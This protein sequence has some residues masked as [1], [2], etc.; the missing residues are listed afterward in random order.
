[1]PAAPALSHTE[2]LLAVRVVEEAVTNA[3]RHGGASRVD[4]VVREEAG[5]LQ[6]VVT[7]N[8]DGYDSQ[9]SEMRQQSGLA[10]LTDRLAIVGGTL[11]I[12]SMVG[13]G[14]TVTAWLPLEGESAFETA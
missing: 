9:S 11:D 8:G 3:L 5:K 12:S 7:D 4:V 1:D 14:A 10:R 2:R 6:V 13:A